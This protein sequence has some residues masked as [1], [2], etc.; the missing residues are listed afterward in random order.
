MEVEAIGHF[1]LLLCNGF[2]LDLKDTFVVSSFRRNLILVS[3]LDKSGYL[4]HLETMHSVCLLIQILLELFHFWLMIIYICLIL[5]PT[6]MKPSIQNLMVLNVKLT[7][8]NREHYG[9]SA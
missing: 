3:Y 8:L 2:Y 7:I 9:T 6:I 5:W 1:R 4:V